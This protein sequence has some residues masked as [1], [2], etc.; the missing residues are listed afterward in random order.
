MLAVPSLRIFFKY[1]KTDFVG[2]TNICLILSAIYICI[3]L[4]GCVGGTLAHCSVRGVDR[5]FTNYFL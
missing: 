4:S 3:P 1:L 5:W 2:N